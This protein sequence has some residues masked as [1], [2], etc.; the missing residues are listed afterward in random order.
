M[1]RGGVAPCT[2]WLCTL[3]GNFACFGPVLGPWGQVLLPL[4][5]AWVVPFCSPSEKWTCLRRL[6]CGLAVLGWSRL[7]HLSFSLINFV[8]CSQVLFGIVCC[9]TM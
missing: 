6:V 9:R 5:V 8:A 7:V 3:V 4:K 1:S 2:R